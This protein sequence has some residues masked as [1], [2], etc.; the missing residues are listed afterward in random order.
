MTNTS[1]YLNRRDRLLYGLR[2]TITDRSQ[3]ICRRPEE[4]YIFIMSEIEAGNGMPIQDLSKD[5]QTTNKDGDTASVNPTSK[6]EANGAATQNTTPTQDATPTKP[7]TPKNTNTQRKPRGPTKAQQL[8]LL[9]SNPLPLKTFPLPTIIPHNP[10]SVL[11]FLYTWASQVLSPPT[12][13]PKTYQGVFSP[14]LRAVHVTDVTSIRALWEQG[15]YGKGSLSR[16]ELSWLDREKRRI[17]E[18]ASKTSEEVTRQRRAERQQVKWERARVQQEAI[19]AKR[20]EEEDA[21]KN[22]HIEKGSVDEMVDAI[23]GHTKPILNDGEVM[24]APT[25]PMQI[26]SMPNSVVDIKEIKTNGHFGERTSTPAPPDASAPSPSENEVLAHPSP[27]SAP[28]TPSASPSK[29]V[30]FS[31]AVDTKTIPADQLLSTTLSNLIIATPEDAEELPLVIKDKEHLQLTTEEAFFLHYGLGVLTIKDSTTRQPISTPHLLSL[32]RRSSYFPIQSEEEVQSGSVRGDDNF[33]INYTVYHHFRSLGW[34]VRGG[35]KFGVDYLLYN[36]GPVFSHAE[37]AVLILP[38]YS[39]PYWSATTERKQYV[40]ERLR[41][42]GK[43]SWLHAVNRV[44]AQVKKTLVLVYVDVPAPQAPEEEGRMGID[45]V[46]ARYTVREI[47][48]KRWV[49]NRSRD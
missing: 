32:F 41:H 7:A 9:Y 3:A 15:F 26:L 4:Y 1:L 27:S 16:S 17:G 49:S 35:V 33:M 14:S 28:T 20:R 30:R 10:L 31:A 5:A 24:G 23:V 13:H 8:A 38:S 34:V 29:A 2:R 47:V 42:R 39:D 25:G 43:W 37:F 44:N 40:Q 22:G 19:E 6:A 45:E 48:L 21:A 11:H 18:G 46:F 12:S 36:R